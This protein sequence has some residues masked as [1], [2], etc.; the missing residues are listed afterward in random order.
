MEKF[1]KRY[2]LSVA[3]KFAEAEGMT[4]TA[5]SRKM[6]GAAHFLDAFEQGDISITLS[7][8]DEMMKKFRHEWPRGIKWPAPPARMHCGGNFILKRME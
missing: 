4:V 8:Y 5:V 6:H 3:K 7:K 1:L 2:M